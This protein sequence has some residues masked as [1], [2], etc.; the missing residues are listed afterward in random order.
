MVA[1]SSS[2][3]ERPGVALRCVDFQRSAPALFAARW[4][5]YT[6]ALRASRSVALDELTCV[7]SLPRASGA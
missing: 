6:A 5:V 4:A 7:A 1:T 3:V 2:S